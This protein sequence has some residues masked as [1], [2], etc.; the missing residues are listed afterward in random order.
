MR[1]LVTDLDIKSQIFTVED[2]DDNKKVQ[3]NPITLRNVLRTHEILNAKLN[4]DN[5]YIVL[6][7]LTRK[8]LF[9]VNIHSTLTGLKSEIINIAEQER[10]IAEQERLEK[11]RLKIEQEKLRVEQEKANIERLRA[12][13][14]RKDAINKEVVSNLNLEKNNIARARAKVNFSNK[15]GNRNS[16]DKTSKF[17]NIYY[18]GKVYLSVNQFLAEV[19]P[20]GNKEFNDNFMELY[21]KGYSLDICLGNKPAS[22]ENLKAKALRELQDRS[23]YY[24]TEISRF[25]E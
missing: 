20:S 9:Q 25:E 22:S 23:C 15:N 10:Q 8:P 1:L 17:K 18:R 2:L 3:S 4:N 13:K 12:E 24:S 21:S 16:Y 5:S 7:N 19:N 14:E 11:E 6:N